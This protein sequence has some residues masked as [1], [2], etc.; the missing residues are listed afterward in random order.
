MDYDK[1][2][3]WR[4]LNQAIMACGPVL[5]HSFEKYGSV[6]RMVAINKLERNPYTNAIVD[7][8]SQFPDVAALSDLIEMWIDH[9]LENAELKALVDETMS[10]ELSA[11]KHA[12]QSPETQWVTDVTLKELIA[13][14]NQDDALGYNVIPASIMALL[15]GQT[16]ALV[17]SGKEPLNIT[18]RKAHD[19][20]TKGLHLVSQPFHPRYLVEKFGGAPDE[21]EEKAA[22]EEAMQDGYFVYSLKVQLETQ[23]GRMENDQLKPWLFLKVGMRRYAHEPFKKDA[24]KRNLSVLLGFNREKIAPENRQKM[25]RYP[26]DTTLISLPIDVQRTPKVWDNN[27]ARLL[28]SYGLSAL[29]DP[30]AVLDA[31]HKYGNLGNIADFRRNEYYIIHAEGRKYSDYED[32]ERR[33]GH[34]HH[35]KVG[36]SLKERT[37]VV[38]RVLELLPD[39]LIPDIAFEPD[40]K[41][42]QG[43]NVP[44]ALRDYKDFAPQGRY[45]PEQT[46][47]KL[48]HTIDAIRRAVQVTGKDCLDIALIHNDTQFLEI[49]QTKLRAMFPG[50]DTGESPF[51]CFH[52]VHISTQLCQPLDPGPLNPQDHYN[53]AR[54]KDF[55]DKW[56]E[57]MK[58]SRYNKVEKEWRPAL[59][60]I[61]WRPNAHRTALIESYY[62][63]KGFKAVHESQEIKGAIREA[64]SREGIASQLIGHFMAGEKGKPSRGNMARL[65]NAILDLMLRNIG[66]FYGTPADMYERAA[67]LSALRVPNLDVVAFW[68]VYK[69]TALRRDEKYLVTV[70][71]VRL[72]SNGCVE[73]F[74]PGFMNWTPYAQAS[75]VLGTKFAE[76]RSPI[77]N[78]DKAPDILQMKNDELMPFV[79]DVL[80][81]RLDAPTIAVIPANWWRNSVSNEYDSARWSQLG[82]KRLFDTQNILDFSHVRGGAKFER[83]DPRFANLLAVIRLR[84]D[85]ETPQYTTGT[86]DWDADKQIGDLDHL[87]GYVDCTVQE[88][89]HYFSIAGESDMQDKQSSDEFEDG[90]KLTIDS[91]YAYKHAQLVELLPFFVRD[92]FRSLEDYKILCRCVHFLRVSP[93]FSKGNILLPYPMHLAKVLLEDLMCIIDAD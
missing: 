11:L 25:V 73:V 53:K 52:P 1:K 67:E 7:I 75:S 70:I 93:A 45:T 14:L 61:A 5:V 21:S 60:K 28:S 38:Q 68:H 29:D 6:R 35:V 12:L 79:Q 55:K 22:L 26:Y 41:A 90:Y 91:D 42:P 47:A 18:W 10:R 51:L 56:A 64:C 54:A 83:S 27:L 16:M 24:Q 58:L 82:N 74:A 77:R 66:A 57:Q 13:N 40:I 63:E 32:E 69:R 31:P 50:C 30:S 89:M 81:H 43:A 65:E 49:L 37:E 4:Q 20:G 44:L 86:L 8:G 59:G 84:K 3:P 46:A 9:W 2:P 34:N 36:F 78:R 33:Y 92:D 23:V 62:D 17:H 19:G 88:P 87:S 85:N 76:L 80:Q 48:N 39:V 15:H 72:C 71:A